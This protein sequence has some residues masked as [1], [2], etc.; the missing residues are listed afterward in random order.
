MGPHMQ[1]SVMSDL[2]GYKDKYEGSCSTGGVDGA[3]Y[4]KFMATGGKLEDLLAHELHSTAWWRTIAHNVRTVLECVLSAKLVEGSHMGW[5]IDYICRGAGVEYHAWSKQDLLIC[6]LA[7]GAVADAALDAVKPIKEYADVLE[8]AFKLMGLEGIESQLSLL[9]LKGEQDVEG[10]PSWHPVRFFGDLELPESV[11]SK[12]VQPASLA[13]F[14]THSQRFARS[15]GCRANTSVSAVHSSGKQYVCGQAFVQDIDAL[16]HY[17]S[18]W[19]V[20]FATGGIIEW[21]NARVNAQAATLAT[22]DWTKALDVDPTPEVAQHVI[23]SEEEVEPGVMIALRLTFFAPPSGKWFSGTVQYGEVAS[24]LVVEMIWRLDEERQVWTLESRETR[25][26]H[27]SPCLVNGVDLKGLDPDAFD[28][29]RV[30]KAGLAQA[31]L[32]ESLVE[33]ALA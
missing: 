27:V 1:V 21:F 18:W 33:R 28:P 5:L 24:D 12:W 6:L 8:R 30:V 17:A 11:Y 29:V 14:L 22:K 15:F 25:L 26:E 9:L 10:A 23:S 7:S 32:E 13:D 19:P 20:A 4:L 2:R 31:K 3:M 16:I